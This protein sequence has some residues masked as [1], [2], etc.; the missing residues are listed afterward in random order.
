ML[1]IKEEIKSRIDITD[2]IAR[3][4][5]I[6]KAGS[7]YK[8]NCPFHNEDTPS[9]MVSPSLQMFKCFGCQKAG[10]IFTFL[11]EIEGLEFKQALVQLAEEAGVDASKY[12]TSHNN[13]NEKIVYKMNET[14]LQFYN[15]C[16]LKS[17][18]GEIAL[19]YL[20]ERGLTKA[21]IEF[22]K[23]GYAPNSW[24]KTFNFLSSKKFT[25]E[26]IYLAGLCKKGNSGKY[27]DVFR[28]RIMFPLISETDK[29]VGFSGRTIVNEDPKYINTK[30]TPVF[31]K[32]NFIYNLQN[33][34]LE[35]KKQNKAIVVEGEFDAISPYIKGIKNIIAL[36]G[37]AFTAGQA[38]LIKRYTDTAVIFFD[39]DLAGQEASIRGIEVAQNEKLNVLVATLPKEYKDPDEA[40]KVSIDIVIK[41][42]DEAVFSYDYFFKYILSIYNVKNP[43]DKVKIANFLKPKISNI[44]EDILKSHYTKKLSE[45]LEMSEGVIDFTKKEVQEKSITKTDYTFAPNLFIY[46]LRSDKKIFKKYFEKVIKNKLCSE[47]EVK[48]LEKYNELVVIKNISLDSFL[49]ENE[50]LQEYF[51]ADLE[52]FETNLNLQEKTLLDMI[53]RN[54]KEKYKNRI[55]LISTKIKLSEENNDVL[56]LDRLKKS[57]RILGKRLSKL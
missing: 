24:D 37:T 49:R 33:T 50:D 29:I 17:K 19:K 51:L 30:E 45:I 53:N 11:M 46:L 57:F 28:G 41:A 36:K 15:Y 25:P 47:Q 18:V 54:L 10:D 34:K 26:Q 1:D 23:L 14:A 48:T 13:D 2:L 4:V 22:F 5:P 44:S 43:I 52:Y 9:F 31:K 21:N 40:S 35:I 16:L 42:V 3:Y 8:A 39:G 56:S 7:N 12:V 32:S 38:K 6:K 20:L 27:Y 55:K